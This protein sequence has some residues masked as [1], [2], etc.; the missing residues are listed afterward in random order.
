MGKRTAPQS[1][2]TTIR[3]LPSTVPAILARIGAPTVRA[4][5]DLAWPIAGTIDAF[6]QEPPGLRGMADS[7]VS[8]SGLRETQ[9]DPSERLFGT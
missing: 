7:T 6:A 5:S 8:T 4:T 2:P 3:G 1:Q 9:D